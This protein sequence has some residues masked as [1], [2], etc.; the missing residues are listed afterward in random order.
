MIACSQPLY[1]SILNNK[2]TPTRLIV[3]GHEYNMSATFM[4][5]WPTYQMS[6]YKLTQ[7]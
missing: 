6:T 5:R 1:N 4:C 7:L 3:G 2:L